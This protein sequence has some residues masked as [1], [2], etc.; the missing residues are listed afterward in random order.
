MKDYN[1][2]PHST[3]G[4]AP[5]WLCYGIK[6]DFGLSALVPEDYMPTGYTTPEADRITALR[7]IEERAERR[8]VLVGNTQFSLGQQVIVQLNSRAKDAHEWHSIAQIIGPGD[9]DETVMVK[10]QNTNAQRPEGLEQVVHVKHLVPLQPDVDVYESLKAG[11]LV[12]APH[13]ISTKRDVVAYIEQIYMVR[14]VDHDGK[15]ED[16]VLLR[17]AGESHNQAQWVLQGDVSNRQLSDAEE[18]VCY[19]SEYLLW[20]P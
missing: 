9:N 1:N 10:F 6:P 17:Y 18:K 4:F 12:E 5:C 16:S 11:A 13:S 7:K 3:T 15:A 14:H 8:T 20:G 2:V 19:Y